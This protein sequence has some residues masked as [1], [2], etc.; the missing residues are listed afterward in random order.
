MATCTIPRVTGICQCALPVKNAFKQ[1]LVPLYNSSG[2]INKFD[3][4]DAVTLQA[5][6]TKFDEIHPLDRFYALPLLENVEDVRGDSVFSEYNSGRKKR[7][8][9]GT[10]TFQ[11]WQPDGDTKYFKRLEEW[12]GGVFGMYV[13]DVDGNFVYNDDGSGEV[14]P[15]PV[16]GN[17]FDPKVVY[18]TDSDAYHVMLMFDYGQYYDDGNT[19]MIPKASL[20]FDGRI[21]GV[22]YGLLP[23]VI[24]MD[25]VEAGTSTKVDVHTDCKVPVTGL[26]FGD[27]AM[28][29]V[30]LDIVLNVTAAVENLNKPGNYEL[31]STATIQGNNTRVTV[32]KVKYETGIV[33]YIAQ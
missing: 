7:L 8:R 14:L 15:I 2:E 27:F 26:L 16:D 30:T 32:A 18:E 24:R 4:V 11:G 23:L 17:S 28:Y 9:Q 1:I 33:E 19:W 31:T 29:D 20:D 13:I 21:P 22:L 25:T 6:Q 12:I 5:L 3:S 10:R